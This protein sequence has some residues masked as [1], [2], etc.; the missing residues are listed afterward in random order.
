MITWF[1]KNPVAANLLMILILVAGAISAL[2]R[3]PLE[4]F[5][6]FA[7]NTLIVRVPYR[8]ASPQDVERGILTRIEEAVQ[9]IVGIEKI[10]SNAK[11]NIGIMTLEFGNE[12][13]Y[14]KIVSEVKNRVDAI[15]TFPEETERPVYS[16][17]VRRRELISVVLYGDLLENDLKVIGESYRN[18]LLLDPEITQV[19]LGGVRYREISIS[20]DQKK[21]EAYNLTISDLRTLVRKQSLDL[22]AG[23]IDS[24]KGRWNIRTQELSE[25]V[26]SLSALLLPIGPDGQNITLSDLAD[27]KDGF[28]EDK[29]GTIFNGKPAVF[30]EVYRVGNQNAITLSNKIKKI[31]EESRMD[32]PAGVQIETWRDFSRIVKGRLS[33]LTWSAIQGGILVFLVLGLFLRFKLALWV[34]LGIPLSFMGA[35]IF[36]PAMG[37]TINIFSLFA[38]I[39]VLGIVVD[40][41]IV[42]GENIF[43]TRDKMDDPVQAAILGTKAVALPVT[44]GILTTIV[45]FIP[46]LNIDGRLGMLFS[47]ISGV[48]IVVLIFSLI[49]SKFILPAHLKHLPKSKPLNEEPWTSRWQQYISRGLESFI[50]NK[51]KPFLK[52]C[53]NYK[54]I[55]LALAVSL[56]AFI[57]AMV[58]NGTIKSS[59]LPAVQSETA[60]GTLVMPEGTPHAYTA[61][62]LEKMRSLAQDLQEEYKHPT[63]GQSAIKN[64]MVNFGFRGAGRRGS[65]H[66]GYIM[67]EFE[68]PEVRDTN[69]TPREFVNEWE[70]RI[71]QIPGVKNL[72][73]RAE[74]GRRGSPISIQLASNNFK[75]LKQSTDSLKGFLKSI[76]GLR[77]IQDDIEDGLPELRLS[78][79]QDAKERG[80]SLRDISTQLRNSVFGA[81]IYRVQQQLDDIRV[82]IRLPKNERVARHNLDNL[83]I[84]INRDTWVPLSS[85]AE[86][87][88]DST[89]AVINRVGGFRTVTVEAD[90]VKDKVDIAVLKDELI[91]F[92]EELMNKQPGLNYSFEGQM[93]DEEKS[94]K[95]LQL[96]FLFS[97]IVIYALLAIPFKSYFQPFIVMSVIPYGIVG[98][99]IGHLITGFN[100]SLM[101]QMGML[102]LIGVVIND[103]LVLVDFVNKRRKEANIPSSQ[104]ALE[105][106]VARFRAI[107]LTSLTTF[108]GLIPL[109]LE[110]STQAKF[111]APMAVSLGFG[112]LLS[113]FVTLVIV[114][115][116]YLVLED[117]KKIFK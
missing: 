60:R 38:F 10:S 72:S 62:Y 43:S 28:E 102:A 29:M 33:T 8:G 77:S 25:D 34:C 110:D 57:W 97:L 19:D 108:A 16:Q 83:R 115:I 4:V 41:A 12:V 70:R 94:N 9:D 27:I 30:L 7:P 63:T 75:T 64:I 3:I 53:L 22:P 31:V 73:F 50:L 52:V 84:R 23:R 39:L 17:P 85:V 45:A 36:M 35:L 109:L 24:A 68:S 99:I 59:R 13:D 42:T 40:D 104:A 114:P 91:I 106:S 18:R 82:M 93:L 2:S 26:R 5:P 86:W 32:L 111:L 66:I 71:G 20:V 76:D 100:L 101:S 1:V 78:L 6:D 117:I 44:F 48:V 105:G 80:I 55:V 87:K 51:F 14:Q 67:V 49:E 47:N 79:K 89:P 113:T 37:I 54:Y 58:Q 65:S 107:L 81:E 88:I 21:L 69:V 90:M 11:E 103:S 15:S 61:K 98:A 74:I 112:V 116:H 92:I 96:G 46:T 95:S 56:C